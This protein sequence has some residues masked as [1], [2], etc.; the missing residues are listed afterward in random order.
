MVMKGLTWASLKNNYSLL[1]LF[2]VVI[3]GGTLAAG[4]ALRSLMFSTDVKINRRNTDRPWESALNDDGTYKP[5]KYVR[6]HDYKKLKRSE[7][8]PQLDN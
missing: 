2:G 6:M 3:L 8:E 4:H 5:Q 7:F 1:P